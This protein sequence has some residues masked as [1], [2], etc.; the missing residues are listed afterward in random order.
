MGLE[1]KK[2]IFLGL[3]LLFEMCMSKS[4]QNYLYIWRYKGVKDKNKTKAARKKN[5]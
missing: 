4:F 1:P 3:I 5:K 2:F